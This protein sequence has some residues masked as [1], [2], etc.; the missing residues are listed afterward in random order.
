MPKMSSR[1]D[2]SLM[3]FAMPKEGEGCLVQRWCSSTQYHL[4]SKRGLEKPPMAPT[5]EISSSIWY[6]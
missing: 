2:T 1:E 4:Y 5:N 3:V 6:T